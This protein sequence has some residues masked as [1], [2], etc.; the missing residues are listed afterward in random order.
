MKNKYLVYILITIAVMLYAS[1]PAQIAQPERVEFIVDENRNF[2]VASAD[3]K[4]L[5]LFRNIDPASNA[6]AIWEVIRLDTALNIL[7]EKEITIEAGATLINKY[8]DHK[9][10]HLLF[11]NENTKDHN[12]LLLSVDGSTGSTSKQAIRNFIPLAFQEFKIIN[13]V[14]LLGGYYNYRPVVILYNLKEKIPRVLP[15]IFDEKSQLI[16]IKINDPFTFDIL[17]KGT[18]VEKNST[19]IIYTFDTQA[20]LIKKI[21]LKTEK[22]KG[23]LFG[24]SEKLQDNSQL[25]A[26]VYG[27]RKSEFSRGVFVANINKYGEQKIRYY[28][29][30]DLKNFFSYMKAKREQRVLRRIERKKIRNKKIR[31]NYRLLVHELIRHDDQYILVGEAFYPKYR[32]DPTGGFFGSG[33]TINRGIHHSNLIFDGY[34]YTHAVIIGFDHKGNLLWDNS[35]EINDV[36]SF[37]LEQFVHVSGTNGKLILLYVFDNTIRSKIIRGNQVLEGKEQN[38]IQVSHTADEAKGTQIGGMEKWYG[39]V[40]YTYGIQELIKKVPTKAPV[41]RKVF[42][43]NKLVYE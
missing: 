33:W 39:D 5:F 22:S 16:E 7:W 41:V 15:G 42:F 13:D 2:E 3:E 35:F 36:M 19:I 10:L 6:T 1:A 29:Y 8:Y 26:G 11:A 30:G 24:R 34:R 38:E 43:V 27:K 28:N 21:A 23:L 12:L 32:T 25:I 40:F 18:T 31:F 20:N 9:D 14:V 4:G 17:L 37:D